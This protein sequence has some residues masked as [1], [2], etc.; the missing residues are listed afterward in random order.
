MK[1]PFGIAQVGKSFRN[2]ITP[3][4]FIFRTREFEQMEMEFFVEPGTDE[5]W[6]EYWIDACEAWY[7]GLGI[8][9]ENLRRFEHPKEKLSHYSKK[10]RRPGVPVP[11]RGQR[12]GRAHGRRQPHRLRPEDPLRE[13]GRRPLV[14]RPDQERALDPVRDRAGVRPDPRADGVPRRRLRRRRGAQHE[15]RRR[16]A[17]RAAPR[18][19]PRAR[20]G[21]RAAAVAQRAAL[22]GR[23]ARSPTR[24]ARTG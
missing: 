19:A 23:Q 11:V 2:E 10:H 14:L 12:V 6:F 16:Q 15:G 17:H 7:L 24:C 9:P 1:P 21:R 8:T 18:P 22:A 20:Q 3:G 5:E 4:N 13:V